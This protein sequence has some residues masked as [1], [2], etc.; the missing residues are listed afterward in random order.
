MEHNYLQ[1]HI[2]LFM[3]PLYRVNVKPKSHTF[4]SVLENKE[5]I[6]LQCVFTEATIRGKRSAMGLFSV[7]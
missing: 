6:H 5:D 7:N 2:Y 4:S 1:C 3:K